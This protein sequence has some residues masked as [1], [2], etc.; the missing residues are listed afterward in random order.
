MA[1]FFLAGQNFDKMTKSVE[2]NVIRHLHEMTIE[3]YQAML[4]SKSIREQAERLSA[5]DL[6]EAKRLFEQ[7]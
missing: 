3:L 6:E 4:I 1:H 7:F 2:A 5:K